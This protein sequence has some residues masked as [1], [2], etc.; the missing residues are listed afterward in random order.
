MR[1]PLLAATLTAACLT[2]S[3]TAQKVQVFGGDTMRASSSLVLFGDNIMAGVVVTHG[4][5]KW[6]D[7]YTDM[8]PQ[9]KGKM[10]RLGS[11]LWTTFMTSVPLEIGGAKV[12]AGSYV[13]GLH[14]DDEGHFSLALLDATKAMKAGKMPFGPQ[15]WEP[16]AKASMKLNKDASDKSVEKMTMML[17]ANDDNPMQG[18]FTI[19]WG[20]AHADRAG[21]DPRGQV[22][23][24]LDRSPEPRAGLAS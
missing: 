20:P 15:K 14:C 3:A 24:R 23:A 6:K 21:Q 8:L 16:D 13:A 17:R 22:A 18:T 10:H 11:N 7:E 5:P 1:F 2:L 4:Q 9:L 19:A 12:A